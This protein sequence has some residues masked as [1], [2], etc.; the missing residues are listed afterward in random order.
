[1]VVIKDGLNSKNVVVSILVYV[2]E[3]WCFM[4]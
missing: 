2:H 3:L 4:P 1:M